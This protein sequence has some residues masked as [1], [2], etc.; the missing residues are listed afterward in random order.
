[1]DDIVSPFVILPLTSPFLLGGAFFFDTS[2]RALSRIV[3][4]RAKNVDDDWLRF[5][6]WLNR[7][8]Q[9]TAMTKARTIPASINSCRFSMIA[10]LTFRSQHYDDGSR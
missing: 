2:I 4:E 5:P 6:P 3:P 8:A 1:M 9:E 10:K 7:A